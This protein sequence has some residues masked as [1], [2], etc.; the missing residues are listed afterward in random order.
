[1]A[2]GEDR[3]I[4]N[5]HVTH[6]P[7]TT[8]AVKRSNEIQLV[9]ASDLDTGV[10]SQDSE[11]LAEET[12]QFPPALFRSLGSHRIFRQLRRIGASLELETA[13]QSLAR[14]SSLEDYSHYLTTVDADF[15]AYWTHDVA[16]ARVK[17]IERDAGC[18]IKFVNGP[19]KFESY[20]T[21]TGLLA[22]QRNAIDQLTKEY[23]KA[24]L[25]SYCTTENTHQW[26]ELRYQLPVRAFLVVVGRCARGLAQYRRMDSCS[27][28]T[29]MDSVQDDK[30]TVQIRGPK[31]AAEYVRRHMD[32]LAHVPDN[33][34]QRSFKA[35]AGA[36]DKRKQLPTDQKNQNEVRASSA[37]ELQS[38]SSNEIS[39]LSANEIQASSAN[40]KSETSLSAR[41]RQLMRQMPHPVVLVTASK[42]DS[43][44]TERN[45][46]DLFNRTDTKNFCAMTVSSMTTVSL[47]PDP[48][49]SFNVKKPSQTLDAIQSQKSFF[50]NL[51]INSPQGAHL[52]HQFSQGDA[53]AAFQKIQ[54][55]GARIQLRPSLFSFTPV[56]SSPGIN[57]HLACTVIPDQCVTVSDHVIVVAKV[58]HISTRRAGRKSGLAYG[59]GSYRQRGTAHSLQEIEQAT[60]ENVSQS[61]KAE[62]TVE[63]GPNVVQALQLQVQLPNRS[64]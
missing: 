12:P 3:P 24:P 18:Q 46:T 55:R 13:S 48:V 19:Y 41:M 37:N 26:V 23:V 40:E 22:S 17:E 52:A 7:F 45:N 43:F 53:Q 34:S 54:E 28:T 2:S 58:H 30:W 32:V 57:G 36:I 56:I 11:L 59:E 47:D 64:S 4:R 1:M 25:E 5:D 51:L 6:R 50:I 62:K 61:E 39:S 29:D 15:A 16:A 27:V 31:D 14:R 20:L 35:Q 33:Q 63:E 49:I 8:E 42:S 44:R 38:F 60:F 9:R 21:V 10:S